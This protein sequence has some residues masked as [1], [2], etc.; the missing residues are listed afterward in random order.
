MRKSVVAL[1]VLASAAAVPAQAE[2]HYGF[3]NVYADYLKWTNGDDHF[4][5]VENNRDKHVTIGAEAGAGFD[6][7]QVYGFYEYEK[8][9]QGSD[10]R[11]QA[12]KFT[13]HYKL[14]DNITAYGQVYDLKDNAFT[15]EQ[16][17]VLGFGY[18]GLNGEGWS[19]NPFIGVHDLSIDTIETRDKDTQVLKS[20]F[21][22]SGFNGYMAG[23]TAMYN[24]DIAGQ[25][26]MLTNW[27][28]IEFDR[29][30]DYAGMQYGKMGHNGGVSLWYDITDTIYTGITYRYFYNKLGVDGYGDAAIFRIGMH[31]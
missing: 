29:N 30:D 5:G 14:V 16:N 2:Y 18:L 17:R 23:W 27:H 12:A 7:G 1:A 19:F 9:D 24:F 31:L 28:E 10:T 13:V 4:G 20:S 22:A 15:N 8:L 21:N 11:S 6:W 26:L 25:P 3:A